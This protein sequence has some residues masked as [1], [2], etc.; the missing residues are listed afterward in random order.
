MGFH[1]KAARTAFFGARA[2]RRTKYVRY[3]VIRYLVSR[4]DFVSTHQITLV[5]SEVD[6]NEV[7]RL[8]HDA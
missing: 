8:A 3:T 5:H 6:F 7:H 2:R 4:G 1:S